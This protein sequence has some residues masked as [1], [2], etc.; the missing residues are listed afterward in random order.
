MSRRARGTDVGLWKQSSRPG[1]L[2][3]F[4]VKYHLEF[5]RSITHT[6]FKLELMGRVKKWIIN[7]YFFF[8]IYV[9]PF[10]HK[11]C[12]HVAQTSVILRM[13]TNMNINWVES[14]LFINV[15]WIVLYVLF[16]QFLSWSL[17]FWI[18]LKIE[19]SVV[20]YF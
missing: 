1:T 10:F 15:I 16:Y 19:L 20:S 9:P 4:N 7:E 17:F 13:K 3:L 18:F 14:I 12:S 2:N 11:S 8:T 6:T 5:P